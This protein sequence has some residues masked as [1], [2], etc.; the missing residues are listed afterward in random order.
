[1]S[2]LDFYWEIKEPQHHV[3]IKIKPSLNSTKLHT[4]AKPETL[5]PRNTFGA[6]EKGHGSL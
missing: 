5:V 4:H 1:M 3:L 2:Y 6:I